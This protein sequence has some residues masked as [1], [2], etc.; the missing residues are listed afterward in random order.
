M[1]LITSP[2]QNH[3]Y[4][5]ETYVTPRP[6][7]TSQ[8]YAYRDGTYSREYTTTPTVVRSEYTPTVVRSEYARSDYAPSIKSNRSHRSHRS[9]RSSSYI[10]A[11]PA[12][13]P[14]ATTTTR[15]VYPAVSQTTELVPVAR[16]ERMYV[17]EEV[18]P[19]RVVYSTPRVS[20][21]LVRDGGYE[22]RRSSS[23]VYY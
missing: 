10:T 20:P 4:T 14:P 2:K 13:L 6:A 7:R 19:P 22:T 5:K 3:E 1:C 17:T 9:R 18:I 12:A 16:E 23:H 15:H 8:V 11:V 21:A